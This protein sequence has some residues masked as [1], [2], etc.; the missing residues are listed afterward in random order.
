MP[1]SLQEAEAASGAPF[2]SLIEGVSQLPVLLPEAQD[3]PSQVLLMLL[4]GA[5]GEGDDRG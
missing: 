3:K 2:S 5:R 4:A 1:G